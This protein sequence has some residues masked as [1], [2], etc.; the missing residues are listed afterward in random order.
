VFRSRDWEIYQIRRFM[1]KGR[2]N[3]LHHLG[4]R[5]RLITMYGEVVA[6]RLIVDLQVAGGDGIIPGEF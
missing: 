4:I 3:N 5:A 6:I 2:A 1:V